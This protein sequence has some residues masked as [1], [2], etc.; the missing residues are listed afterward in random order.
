MRQAAFEH[1]R[2]LCATK[3]VIEARELEKGF[4]FQGERILL[5]SRAR[6]IFKPRQ[7]RHPLSIK[8]V[9]PR[10]GRR[11]RY[12]DQLDVHRPIY[13][14]A[15]TLDYAFMGADPDAP[16][17]RG[18]REAWENRIPLI[19]FIGVTAGSYLAEFPTWVVGWDAQA[20]RVQLAFAEPLMQV[21]DLVGENDDG[22][23][24]YAVGQ[25]AHRLHQASFR[26]HL[27][28]V[29]KGR[30]AVSGLPDQRLLDAAHIIADS[31]EFHGQPVVQN[32]ILLS[33]L[34]H[35]AF[36]AKLL[37]IDPDYRLHVSERLLCLRDGPTLQALQQLE[38]GALHLPSRESDRPDRDRLA[39]RYEEFKAAS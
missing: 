18:L 21:G 36:D 7:M 37:G 30:C 13:N 22:R 23:R 11:P 25:V 9:L 14:S 32:G 26:Q 24:R 3:R 2:R 19:Y 8:T 35:A 28:E 29:Y 34:H 12:H 20:L 27:L 17:N 5:H 16:D 33:K 10:R 38:G 39:I 4:T 1:L 6:G 15:G 31:D